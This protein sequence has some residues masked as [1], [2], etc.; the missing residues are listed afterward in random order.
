MSRMLMRSDDSQINAVN[1]SE[2]ST[3]RNI[4]ICMKVF[5]LILF[6]F[7][8]SFSNAQSTSAFNWEDLGL[9]DE[10]A[11]P[12]GTTLMSTC[13]NYE[14]T[15]TWTTVT[16][17]GSFVPFSG[18][19]HISYDVSSET[20][21]ETGDLIMGFDNEALDPG[22]RVVL[23]LSF[24]PEICD[25]FFSVTD[26][27][28][29]NGGWV[30]AIEVF[31][32]GANVT[33]TP[34]FFTLSGSCVMLDDE[35]FMD[36]FEGICSSNAL[37]P[38]SNVVFD[39]DCDNCIS[40]IQI[41]HFSGDDDI[42]TM[43][44]VGQRINLDDI[45]FDKEC[46]M[47]AC[48]ALEKS[49]TL[50][51]GLDGVATVG[52]IITYSYEVMNCG[53]L[54]LTNLVITED[55]MLFTGTGTLPTPSAVTPATLTPLGVGTATASY[56]IT[57]ADID[58]GIVT[59]QAT[60]TANRVGTIEEV[61]DISDSGNPN[62]EMGT[63]EDP[64][65]EPIP[66]NPCISLVKSSTL[67]L[68]AD[69][70]ANPGDIITYAYEVMNCGSVTLSSV[71]IQEDAMSF[72]GTGTLPTPTAVM[73]STL[74][75]NE[76]GTATATYAITQDDI[77]EGMVTNQAEVSAVTVDNVPVNDLSDSGNPADEMGMDE[78]LTVE[79][80]P[81]EACIELIKSSTLDL[82]ADGL[83]NPGDIIE[84]T[85]T[86]TNCGPTQITGI[87]VNENAASFTGT[88]GLPM[89]IVGT[90]ATIDPGLSCMI[91]GTQYAITA[92]DI[93]A[94]F[95]DNQ[96]TVS[97]MDPSGNSVMDVSDS[98]NM[99]DEAGTN[100]DV[101]TE[102]IPE[103][104]CI[105][106]EKSSVL[107]LG[108][109]GIANPGDLITYSYEV[110][111]C[112]NVD[113]NN[114]QILEDATMF[115]GT[116]TLPAPTAVSPAT[117]TAFGGTG[118]ASATYA[119]TQDDINAGVVTNKAMASGMT[120]SAATV[121]ADSDSGN[122]ADEMGTEEDDTNEP[123]PQTPCIEL[124]KSSNLDLGADGIAMPGDIITYNYVVENCGNVTLS[125]VMISEDPALF[126]GTGSLP[127]PTSVTP[128]TLLPGETGTSSA[129]Y[130]ITQEDINT[131]IVT[132]QADAIGMDPDNNPVEDTS[133][134]G[135]YWR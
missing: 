49:S 108:A 46:N 25:A 87:T 110:T 96:A 116:G 10:D 78:D 22:D 45:D 89:P 99:A 53:D 19:D 103:S 95:V 100:E 70:I 27:D 130:A 24:E 73:P 6:S 28:L 52:D 17:G 16:N 30:D 79:P 65:N 4:Y 39:Y 69:G 3:R 122:P 11:I 68:G 72:T 131:G 50:D 74:G 106:L 33:A 127:I 80:I 86:I 56:S 47:L 64:T 44:P 123:I 102:T 15:I 101:T 26:V 104:G 43:D 21:G 62:D 57:Q 98:G 61:M 114:L 59:N 121:M 14:M 88:G 55:P 119:I 23:T 128:M 35:T 18:A 126:T 12:S 97:G 133:D 31:I 1:E 82:G 58:A 134:S 76:M 120:P 117:L 2:I 40:E 124:I 41:M 63:L 81:N 93:A 7:T 48:I 85:Y 67:D 29:L 92:A 84:Y 66:N 132:N 107:D 94:G 38:F 91:T 111:N 109:D 51:L 37:N 112:G 5:C 34:Q 42:S 129:T 8:I 20:M 32:N 118:T 83:A 77:D 71:S 9:N 115:T 36:G 125:N 13:G 54:D 90:C 113:L 60:I 105:S 135:K 75:P